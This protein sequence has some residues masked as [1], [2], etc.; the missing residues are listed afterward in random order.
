MAWAPLAAAGISAAAG[1]AGGLM[2]GGGS[3]GTQTATQQSQLPGWIN[4]QT[5]LNYGNLT[6]ALWDMPGPYTGNRVA[7]LTP[8]QRNLIQQLYGNVGSTNAG[9]DQASGLTN[10]LAG[11]TGSTITPQTLAGMNLDPYMNP[12]VSSV[13]NPSLTLMDQSLANQ[14]N[15]AAASAAQNRAFG[16]SR[17]GVQ[18]A[19][20]AAQTNLL[21]GQLGGQLYGT[22][23]NQAQQAAVGDISRNLTAQQYN[24]SA[25]LQAAQL[26]GNMAAQLANL[27]AGRQQ[28]YLTG[29]S[30]A[31]GGQDV[32]WKNEQDKINA[33]MALYNDQ[34]MDRINRIMMNQNFLN[35]NPVANMYTQTS[36]RP[37]PST[38]PLSTGLG[39]AA[40]TAG[41]FGTFGKLFGGGGIGTA[42]TTYYPT[43]MGGADMYGTGAFGLGPGG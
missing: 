30:A 14:Q 32:L 5:M 41:L 9:F 21:K 35:N 3:G 11:F 24:Q 23:F 31:M 27:A 18:E 17:Q 28:N 10:A 4:D 22:A 25:G 19:V 26:R 13:I 43:G 40:T 36:T 39:T 42:G 16:G 34:R 33:A 2:K 20:N 15:A 7:D 1:L 8:E 29:V 37:G 6:Q 38:D 12:Y